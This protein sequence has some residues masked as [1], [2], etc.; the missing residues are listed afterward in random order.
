MQ[1]IKEVGGLTVRLST[2]PAFQAHVRLDV[3]S[4]QGRGVI[5]RVAPALEIWGVLR[6]EG[7]DSQGDTL[8]GWC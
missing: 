6:G 3:A 8:E 2:L 1:H 5:M 7:K 4:S